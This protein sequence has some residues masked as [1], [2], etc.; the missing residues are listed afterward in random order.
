MLV[1][2][3][4]CP[5]NDSGLFKKYCWILFGFILHTS[6]QI[7]TKHIRKLLF[8]LTFLRSFSLITDLLDTEICHVATAIHC[9]QWTIH[10]RVCLGHI[11]DGH[12]GV[13]AGTRTSVRW[14]WFCIESTRNPI[15]Q[16]GYIAV[17]VIIIIVIIMVLYVSSSYGWN[18]NNRM[19]RSLSSIIYSCEHQLTWSTLCPLMPQ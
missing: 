17:I 5:L 4:S 14:G 7:S 13:P 11:I 18:D 6:T 12:A 15:I 9:S 16:K 10:L 3:V 8:L 2:S 19:F 1:S